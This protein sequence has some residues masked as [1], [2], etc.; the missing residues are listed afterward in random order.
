MPSPHIHIPSGIY[1]VARLEARGI[2]L[3][4]ALPFP[5]R[6]GRTVLGRNVE[7]DLLALL[8]LLLLLLS[9]LVGG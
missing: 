6:A 7:L 2:V 8:P 5:I 9:L 3:A 1:P 4:S